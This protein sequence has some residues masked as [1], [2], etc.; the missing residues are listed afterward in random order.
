[1]NP[2]SY[3]AFSQT[4]Y[5]NSFQLSKAE[6]EAG[7]RRQLSEQDDEQSTSAERREL[8]SYIAVPPHCP[9]TA[10]LATEVTYDVAAASAN[11]AH[12]WLRSDSIFEQMLD[13]V[14]YYILHDALISALYKVAEVLEFVESGVYVLEAV[15]QVPPSQTAES[16]MAST[17]FQ[18]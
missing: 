1:M 11:M 9:T 17:D 7:F 3:S 2:V 13:Q 5:Y 8:A 16:L 18:L 6:Y 10:E 12:S 15:M 14:N 4:P